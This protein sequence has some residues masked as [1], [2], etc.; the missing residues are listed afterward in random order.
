MDTL[1][2]I[3]ETTAFERVSSGHVFT[4][5]PLWHPYGFFFYFTDVRASLLHRM[6]PG[7]ARFGG[8]RDPRR[9][10]HDIRPARPPD[11]VRG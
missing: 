2:D 11:H 7:H 10:R 8:A 6:A 1:A 3:L 9:Q 5:G 4:E